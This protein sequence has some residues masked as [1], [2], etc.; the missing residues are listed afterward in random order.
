MNPYKS[1]PIYDPPTV[2][3]YRGA[4]LGELPPHIFAVADNAYRR[5]LKD[6]RNQCMI[7]SGESGAGKTENTKIILQYLAMLSGKHSQ[8]EERIL[9][10]SPI[11]EAFGNACTV[12]NNNSSRFGKYIEILFDEQ[13][14]IKG[15]K[16]NEYL[17]EKSRIINQASKERNYHSFYCLLAGAKDS[18]KQSLKLTKA[19]DYSYLNKGGIVKVDS[20]NDKEDFER[21]K[22]A[23]E[24]IGVNS[25]IQVSLWKLLAIILHLGNIQFSKADNDDV[26]VIKNTQPLECA[27]EL[28]QMT[29]DELRMALVNKSNVTRGETIVSPLNPAQAADGRDALAKAAYGWLFGWLVKLVNDKIEVPDS[30]NS[31]GVLDIFG[32]EDFEKNSFEQLC[33]NFANEKLQ[34]FFNNHIFKLEQEEYRNEGI[35]F[36]EI[37]YQDNQPCLEMISKKPSGIIQLLDDESNFPKASDKTFVEKVAK[38]HEKNTFFDKQKTSESTFSV[39][40]YAGKVT[41]DSSG[42]LDKNRDLLRADLEKLCTD[43]KFSFL[44]EVKVV[45]QLDDQL[46]RSSSNRA[47]VVGHGTTTISAKIKTVGGKFDESLQMLISVLNNCDPHFVRCVKPNTVKKPDVFEEEMVL[48]QL[49]YSGLMETVRIRQSGYPVRKRYRDFLSRYRPLMKNSNIEDDTKACEVFLKSEPQI[50][51]MYQIGKT[52]VFYKEFADSYLEKKR[53]EKLKTIAVVIQRYVRGYLAKKAYQKK[54]K[55]ASKIQATWKMHAAI[56]AK[57]LRIKA[58]KKIQVFWR[59]Q[60]ARNQLGR[61]K[62]AVSVVQ[63]VLRFRLSRGFVAYMAHQAELRKNAEKMKQLNIEAS[64]AAMNAINEHNENIVKFIEKSLG[65]IASKKL[66]E[67]FSDSFYKSPVSISEPV[68]VKIDPAFENDV[69]MASFEFSKYVAA[70]FV[71]KDDKF[72]GVPLKKPVLSIVNDKLAETCA[73]IHQSL[74]SLLDNTTFQSNF[75]QL[76]RLKFIIQSCLT[77]TSLCDEVYSQLCK[78]MNENPKTECIVL[79][80]RLMSLLFQY[81]PPSNTMLKFLFKYI[82][83]NA[84]QPIIPTLKRRLIRSS[85]VGKRVTVPSYEELC[86]AGSLEI[87]VGVSLPDGKKITVDVDPMLSCHELMVEC[88]KQLQVTSFP[89]WALFYDSKQKRYRVDDF[90]H[91][92]DLDSVETK[93]SLAENR[94]HLPINFAMV[95]EVLEPEEVIRDEILVEMILSQVKRSL[96]SVKSEIE[97]DSAAKLIAMIRQ[98]EKL[99]EPPAQSA[100]TFLSESCSSYTQ[101]ENFL[102]LVDKYQKGYSQETRSVLRK[103]IIYTAAEIPGIIGRK[104]SIKCDSPVIFSKNP[105]LIQNKIQLCIDKTGINFLLEEDASVFYVLSYAGITVSEEGKFLVLKSESDTIKLEPLDCK[106]DVIKE[107]IRKFEIGLVRTSKWAVAL[108]DHG[109]QG[110]PALLIMKEGDVIEIIEKKADWWKGRNHSFTIVV[111]GFFPRGLV[112]LIVSKPQTIQKRTLVTDSEIDADG[113]AKLPTLSAMSVTTSTSLITHSTGSGSEEGHQRQPSGPGSGSSS[114][115]PVLEWALRNF[116][117]D[118]KKKKLMPD[119]VKGTIRRLTGGDFN[120]KEPE[121]D[122][123]RV[124]DK[125]QFTMLPIRHSLTK[126]LTGDDEKLAVECFQI[127]MK[128]MGDYPVKEQTSVDLAKLL[129]EK[130]LS[131]KEEFRTEVY[132]YF[133]RQL[134]NNSNAA[135]EAK[136]WWFLQLV[137]GYFAPSSAFTAVFLKWLQLR[138]VSQG[139]QYR[140]EAENIEKNVYA[141][142]RFGPRRCSPTQEEITYQEL[143]RPLTIQVNFMDRS[144][145][146]IQIAPCSV[147]AEIPQQ[148]CQKLDIIDSSQFVLYAYHNDSFAMLF[149]EEYVLDAINPNDPPHS[150]VK[151]SP[152]KLYLKKIVWRSNEVPRNLQMT[153]MMF[154]QLVDFYLTGFTTPSSA[155]ACTLACILCRA[156][157]VDL[158]NKDEAKKEEICRSYIPALTFSVKSSTAW[159]KEL[160]G[161][162]GTYMALDVNAAKKKFITAAQ[163][164]KLYGASTFSASEL[165]CDKF[166]LPENGVLIFSPSALIV[167]DPAKKASCKE[168]PYNAISG[169]SYSSDRVNL[170]LGGL[171]E[172]DQTILTAVTPLGREICFTLEIFG[173]LAMEAQGG[174]RFQNPA[175]G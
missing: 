97:M 63:T 30:K 81:F 129:L 58:V 171:M 132:V 94:N 46:K 126:Q 79:G 50:A 14:V 163:S 21:L 137:S 84:P 20:L 38:A 34:Q 165:K 68:S 47:S 72:S 22:A 59:G 123:N 160:E 96:K 121:L 147:V 56:K 167:F 5:M 151:S 67:E 149:P 1:L 19:E 156:A 7:I 115:V 78:Q 27:A 143:G 15:G 101:N 66:D 53:S 39:I 80:W 119:G 4:A 166:A 8:T 107:M 42:F 43:S 88:M 170:K 26:A 133:L 141:T 138:N 65:T 124:K 125:L 154:S 110:D 130:C 120:L 146:R 111:E 100:K 159:I 57:R 69:E 114:L 16:L 32:F 139:F 2:R 24:N 44:S 157:G 29:V 64:N 33:I 17:L 13:G 41:Y 60:V 52:R 116:R 71:S 150:K 140:N 51:K 83:D 18:E 155:E 37:K 173:H 70:Y 106:M 175:L 109:N 134:T 99:T 61:L 105:A 89:G 54:K 104:F 158:L 144:S 152:K 28:L 118:S 36:E 31:I 82:A 113:T 6:S 11:L 76:D 162:M 40:H 62:H 117:N 91:I 168:W 161:L 74:L 174:N 3:S 48:L 172:K 25:E 128:F 9:S 35:S 86:K 85:F 164:W 93:K 92:L 142:L 148:V 127:V 102:S 136:G 45:A 98:V 145:K 77:E 49:R 90:A 153:N 112:N 131:K 10:S 95:K 108:G 75:G 169:Y 73:A 23:L 55:A 12:R 103:T 122:V 87:N 135:S